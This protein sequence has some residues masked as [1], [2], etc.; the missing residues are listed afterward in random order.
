MGTIYTGC[1]GG[2]GVHTAD[3]TCGRRFPNLL[4]SGPGGAR[5][6]DDTASAA[7]DFRKPKGPQPMR[8]TILLTA[9]MTALCL[10][11]PLPA[12]DWPQWRGP[13]RDGVWQES[14]LVDRFDGPE[15]EIRWRAEAW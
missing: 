8:S 3:L 7:A 5:T 10:S 6:N 15:L 11:V 13:G 12:D 1:Q 14:G 9:T 2:G 4:S